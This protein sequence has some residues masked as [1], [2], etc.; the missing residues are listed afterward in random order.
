[1]SVGELG[2]KGVDPRLSATPKGNEL[3]ERSSHLAALRASLA[4][5][6]SGA[7]GRLVLVGG[8]AGVGKTTLVRRFCAEHERIARVLS[9]ACEALFTPRALGPF[10]TIAETTGGELG[11]LVASGARPHE[12]VAALMSELAAHKTTILVVEDVHWAD[13]ATLD[14]LRLLGRRID[15]V[16]ALVLATYRDD[17]L[18]R[19]HPLRLVLGELP[20]GGAIERLKL[21]PLSPAA[22]GK[23]AQTRG[24]DVDELYRLTGGNPFFVTEAL[25]AGQREVPASVRDAV[26]ARAARLSPGANTVLEAVAIVPGQAE[27]RLLEALGAE[28]ITF[29]D[30]CVAAGMLVAVPGGVSFRHEL[31]R[32]AVEESLPPA[33][34]L[35]LHRAML[36]ALAVPAAGAPDFARLAHHAEAA[37]EAEAVLRYAPAAAARASSLGAHR[38]AAAQYARA[39]RF[40]DAAQPQTL[41]RLLE[42]RAQECYLTGQFSEAIEAEERALKLHRSAGDVREEGDALRRL[43]RLRFYVGEVR[44]AKESGRQAAE[45]LERLPAGRELAWAYS[46]QAMFEEDAEAVY[47][48]GT[49]AV[50]LAQRLDEPEI[51]CHA[52]TNLG[53]H[54]LLNGLAAGR[55]KLE[56][57]LELALQ[58]GFEEA[59]G[60]AFSLLAIAAVRI[61]S[62]DLAE[63]VLT[64]GIEYASE[65]DLGNYRLIQLA[66]R[67][68]L[69]LDL[70]HWTDALA[71]AQAA[72]QEDTKPYRV[73]ALPVVGL[74][75]A[76]RGEPGVW[77]ALDEALTLAPADELLRAAPL[78]AARAEA[79]WLEGRPE[80]VVEATEET[81]QLALQ[82]HAGWAFGELAFWRWRAGA[83]D[84]IPNG[85]P[86]HYAA[87][88]AGNWARAAELWLQLGC[89][90]EAALA[91][92]D[93][94]VEEPLLRALD[95]L[96]GL[97]AHAA[98]ET[99]ARRL[100]KR[101]VRG[102][103]R[104]PR[105][106]TRRN[107]AN[108]T[109]REVEVLALL[110]GGLHNAQIA[111]RLFL[112]TKTVDHHVSAIL[113]KLGVPTR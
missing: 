16:S 24:L 105:P 6:R 92:A 49:R 71:S 96:Q 33:R 21:E 17:E 87:Q 72:L 113:R 31:A 42:G 50:E 9:G 53:T 94:D 91:L 95:Q 70:G 108:L 82:L 18:A 43:S 23:L 7:G 97:G 64:R 26:L 63:D 65:R 46:T 86:E 84:A 10:M 19:A 67:A 90:Y 103:P 104:G 56:R 58:A 8:E 20:I 57:S 45:L 62:Y 55:D 93:A 1:M 5:V 76:R 88:I 75:R 61:R 78:A 110:A 27:L 48:W 89:P 66:Q 44:Q 34:L 14:V 85:V 77:Q 100:R 109:P 112:S 30:E 40:A 47:A 79:A 25:A 37:H 111:Q 81:F 3:L 32:L 99:V 52:L 29:L 36:A 102:V 106:T 98:A 12:V 15:H 83:P 54:E 68:R 4:A 41:V 80:A 73:F 2:P 60:R 39:L 101:G 51:L 38:E 107:P 35:S 59:A 22:V 13:Q 74:V 11:E 28:D 69:Q